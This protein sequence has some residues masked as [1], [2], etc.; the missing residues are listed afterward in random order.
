[1]WWDMSLGSQLLW[2]EEGENGGAVLWEG[3]KIAY[4]SGARKLM[5]GH[6]RPRV[7][8][9]ECLQWGHQGLLGRVSWLKVGKWADRIHHDP[10]HQHQLA[11]SSPPLQHK[12][13]GR[14]P[15]ENWPRKRGWWGVPP[16]KLEWI[17]RK[18][19]QGKHRVYAGCILVSWGCWNK[20]LQT[21]LLKPRGFIG[22]REEV[23]N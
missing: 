20:L 23:W 19:T 4:G 3:I 14:Q 1:M 18:S 2:W 16:L 22:W 12:S 17:R 8:M 21:G 11:H 9:F 10:P 7:S 15:Q 6:G 5:G 13:W